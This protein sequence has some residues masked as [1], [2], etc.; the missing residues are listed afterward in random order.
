MITFAVCD[1]EPAMLDALCVEIHTWMQ[2]RGEAD[3]HISCFSGGR[4]LL[5]STEDF[6]VVFLDIQMEHPD[7]MET[8]KML[9]QRSGDTVLIFVTVSKEYVFDAFEVT[10][11]DYLLK[12]LNRE[13]F[14]RTMNRVLTSFNQSAPSIVVQKGTS[15]AVIPLA[16]IVYCEVQGRKIYIHQENGTITDYYDRLEELERRLDRRFFKCHRS[17]L[18]NLDKVRGCH[19][20]QAA[21]SDGSEIPVSRLRERQLTE[22][23]LRHMKETRGSYG[24]FQ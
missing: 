13:R 16:Q 9:R 15:C 17:Y 6:D 3:Y 7:G 11:Y 21:L 1:D 2:E 18:V 20:G 24:Y 8:A 12:P 23:L 4:A 19:A 14:Q 10:A 5:E 22:A